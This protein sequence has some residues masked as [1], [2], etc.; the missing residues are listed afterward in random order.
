MRY[1]ALTVVII[2]LATFY[3]QSVIEVKMAEK[4]LLE[5]QI[6]RVQ[7]ETAKERHTLALWEANRLKGEK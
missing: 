3:A 6:E 2:I 4:K 1:I 5:A 7:A